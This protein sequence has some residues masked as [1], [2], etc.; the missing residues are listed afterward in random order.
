M[1]GITKLPSLL[2]LLAIL[3]V[4]PGCG[5]DEISGEIPPANATVLNDALDGVSTAIADQDCETA[6]S[7]ADEFVNAVNALPANPSADLKPELQAAGDNLRTLVSDECA[8]TEPTQPTHT[9]QPT[10]SSTTSTTTSSTEETDTTTTSTTTSTDETEPPGNGQ[11]Q[12]PGSG[13][14]PGQGTDGGTGDTGGTG[15]GSGD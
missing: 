3:A 8:T 13:G 5:S 14:P 9:Q 15:S 4:L 11:G 1:P 2:A 7:R 10:T 6:A 12:G